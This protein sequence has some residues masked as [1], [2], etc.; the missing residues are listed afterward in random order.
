MTRYIYLY[1][2][3]QCKRLIGIDKFSQ[4]ILDRS[5]MTC[6]KF[7]KTLPHDLQQNVNIRAS[8]ILF[9]HLKKLINSLP[10]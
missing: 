7:E 9:K 2:T 1:T 3:L 4:L 6:D 5:N 10:G 8:L